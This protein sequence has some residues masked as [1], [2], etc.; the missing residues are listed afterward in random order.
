[1]AR[2]AAGWGLGL[3]CALALGGAVLAFDELAGFF[4]MGFFAA[5]FSSP[6]ESDESDES[7]F[8]EIGF[9]SVGLIGAGFFGACLTSSEESLSALSSDD[10]IVLSSLPNDDNILTRLV[11]TATGIL[12]SLLSYELLSSLDSGDKT[13]LTRLKRNPGTGGGGSTGRDWFPAPKSPFQPYLGCS[14]GM[15]KSTR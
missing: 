2:L 15:L 1:M 10:V 14:S 11:L 3:G 6:D 5:C 9:L 13:G 4:T 12:S 7:L 8:D